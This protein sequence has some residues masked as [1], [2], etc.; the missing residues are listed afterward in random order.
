MVHIVF[1][2]EGD[3]IMFKII[4]K[5]PKSGNNANFAPGNTAKAAIA[6]LK[7]FLHPD[8]AAQIEIVSVARA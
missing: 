1:I 7:L 6:Y 2:N 4:W 5:T 3:L 8:V